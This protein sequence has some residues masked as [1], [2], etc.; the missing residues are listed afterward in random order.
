M[1]I[2]AAA[3]SCQISSRSAIHSGL[4]LFKICIVWPCYCGKYDFSLDVAL[5][6]IHSSPQSFK[7]CTV[8]PWFFVAAE[9]YDIKSDIFGS[10]LAA[11]SILAN[12]KKKWVVAVAH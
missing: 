7:L 5:S 6:Y 10:F 1:K 2:R 11:L 9:K 4:E 8:L 12:V 3:S